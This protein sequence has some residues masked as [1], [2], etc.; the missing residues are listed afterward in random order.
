MSFGQSRSRQPQ[1]LPREE[2]RYKLATGYHRRGLY[3]E[4]LEVYRD[5][6]QQKGKISDDM[7]LKRIA[8][9]EYGIQKQKNPEP[10][11]IAKLDSLVN[12][13]GYANF[14]AFAMDGERTLYFTSSRFSSTAGAA[15]PSAPQPSASELLDRV[16]VARR[17]TLTAPWKVSVLA[18]VE[19]SQFHEG[20]LNVS[21]D[22]HFL[23]IFRGNN[24]IFVQDIQ[25][26]PQRVKF[27]PIAQVFNLKVSNKQHISSLAMT[28]RGQTMYVCIDGGRGDDKKGQGGYDIWQATRNTATGVWSEL[29]NLGTTI[30]TAGNEV[31]VSALPDGKTIYFASDGLQG[32]GGYDIYCS[33]YVDSLRAWS[34]PSHLGYPINTPN[35]DVYYNPV[36]DNPSHAYYSVGK[37]DVADAYDIYLVSCYG[38]ILSDEEKERRRQRFLRALRDVQVEPLSPKTAKRIAKKKYTP[39]SENT[40]ATVGVKMLF[41]EIQFSKNKSKILAKSYKSLDALYC[42]MTWHTGVK[43]RIAGYTDNVGKK[44]ANYKISRARAQSVASY[45]IQKGIDPARIDVKG[46]GRKRPVASNKTEAG[47]ALNRRVEVSVIAR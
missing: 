11:T 34:K 46:Y 1:E 4:A 15:T 30:N 22:G 13:A 18:D 16:C 42:W 2:A 24:E 6:H 10:V 27:V 21:P 7:L 45:L 37:P 31:S 36:L 32:V 5:L 43:I 44:A 23:F 9:C 25:Q 3:K 41:R 17:E 47:R 19:S 8:E 39:F 40:P 29:V 26:L 14:S 38:E 12:T 33:T 35:N 20:V 28:N